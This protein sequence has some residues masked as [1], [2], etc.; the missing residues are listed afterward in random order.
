MKG[1]Y[2]F[3]VIPSDTKIICNRLS[4]FFIIHFHKNKYQLQQNIVQ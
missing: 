3:G 1:N 2:Y 4:N